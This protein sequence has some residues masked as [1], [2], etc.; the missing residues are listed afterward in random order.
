MVPILAVVNGFYRSGTTII[1]KIIK[2]ENPDKVVFYE[3]CHA[4]LFEKINA[5]EESG[6]VK[7]AWHGMALWDEYLEYKEILPSL[8]Q[9]HPNIGKSLPD[10]MMKLNRYIDI[11]HTLP[12]TDVIL[13][14]NR[15]HFVLDHLPFEC[16]LFH[17][18]RSPLDVFNSMI[19]QY[20]NQGR[21]K[22]LKKTGLMDMFAFGINQMFDYVTIHYGSRIHR[23]FAFFKKTGNSIFSKFLI[24]WVLSNWVAISTV[25]D[26]EGTILTY[27]KL[28]SD[29]AS[30]ENIFRRKGI[31]FSTR[32]IHTAKQ[33]SGYLSGYLL[34]QI[35]SVGLSDEYKMI[36]SAIGGTNK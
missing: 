17:V 32:K 28:V 25:L 14:T 1:W 19:T 15:W 21:F 27:E 30:V 36:R 29:A 2:D 20:R 16:S 23:K 22:L 4:N 24:V 33:S 18:I 11:F 7:D 26:R 9:W 6:R 8:R 31:R 12:H 13:Q 5:Y 35:E 34:Q 3:P 10:N